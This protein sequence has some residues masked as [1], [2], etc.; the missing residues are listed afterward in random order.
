MT[1]FESCY[2]KISL[3]VIQTGQWELSLWLRQK[4]VVYIYIFTMNQGLSLAKLDSKFAYK[5][6]RDCFWITFSVSVSSMLAFFVSSLFGCSIA[7]SASL[8]F[9][10]CLTASDHFW[11]LLTASGCF[12]LFAS[13]LLFC[14]CF[15]LAFHWLFS[16][17]S[18]FLSCFYLAFL[19]LY[20]PAPLHLL[21]CRCFY[22]AFLLLCC[23]F[24][25][26]LHSRF[27]ASLLFPCL[28]FFCILLHSCAFCIL[29]FP[30]FHCSLLFACFL[31]ERN[32]V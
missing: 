16:C 20:F 7:C 27:F 29:T 9:C 14:F 25:G 5:T 23:C 21:L 12:W 22:L 8:S 19:L 32:W 4:H 26:Y 6:W 1:S 2:C 28:A 11:L 31:D 30:L 24:C 18:F 3:S 15:P 17:F 13:L 10:F